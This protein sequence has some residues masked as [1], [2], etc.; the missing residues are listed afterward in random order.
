MFAT[1]QL[2]AH[3]LHHALVFV[4]RLVAMTTI[5]ASSKASLWKKFEP[6]YIPQVVQAITD[7]VR[8]VIHAGAVRVVV[9][10]NFPIGCIPIYLTAF[11]TSDPRAYDN[12]GCLASLNGFARYHNDYLQSALAELRTEF[13]N[14]VI[15]YGD[16]YSAFESIIHRAA[17]LGFDVAMHRKHVAGFGGAYNFDTNRMCGSPGVPVC[18]NPARCIHWDGVHLTQDAY[19]HMAQ[20]LLADL[21]PEVQ[22]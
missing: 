21:L 19:M 20:W 8:E 5:M 3:R 6:T 18:P 7:A 12:M 9:P 10:M 16:C 14:A 2:N 11:Q 13:P 22:Y 17:S 4:E 1:I 15:L